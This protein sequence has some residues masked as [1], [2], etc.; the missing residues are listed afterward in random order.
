M[1]QIIK[2]NSGG[3]G[4]GG[5]ATGFFAYQNVDIA[6]AIGASTFFVPAFPATLRNDGGAFNT[7]SGVFTAPKTGL[8]SFQSTI[9]IDNIVTSTELAIGY[10]G[11]VQS[12]TLVLLGAGSIGAFQNACLNA[13]WSMQMTAGDTVHMT[14]FSNEATLTVTLL[15]A[16]IS[17]SI[18][19]G[20]SSFSG[21]LVGT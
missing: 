8:Y 7:S 17:P 21:F 11:S 9:N 1:S 10:T 18:F 19:N 20:Q 13:A 12:E 4:G 3:G 5:V 16:A 14:V 2:N 6:N 15:G